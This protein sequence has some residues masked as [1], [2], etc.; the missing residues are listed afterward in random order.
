MHLQQQN[1]CS[2][3]SVHASDPP[4]LDLTAASA[5]P[6]CVSGEAHSVEQ[7]ITLFKEPE[8]YMESKLIYLPLRKH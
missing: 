8:N 4:S 7:V 6:T 2:Q 5:S 3:T 1:H